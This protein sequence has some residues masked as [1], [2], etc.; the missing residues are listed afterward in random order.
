MTVFLPICL[1]PQA[2]ADTVADKFEGGAF[3]LPLELWSAAED[4]RGSLM[5]R[6]GTDKF[7]DELPNSAGAVAVKTSTPDRVASISAS[8]IMDES[9]MRSSCCKA[10]SI[11]SRTGDDTGA[12]AAP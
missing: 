7:G 9:S 11:I 12:E 3:S 4:M 2:L 8:T 1:V 6:I 5:I 10:E